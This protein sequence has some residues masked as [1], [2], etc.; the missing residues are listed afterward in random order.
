[1]RI[2]LYHNAPSGGAKRAIFE[3]SIRLAGRY[4][5]DVY[6]LSTG[7]HAYCDIRPIVHSH[8]VY[9]FA[10]RRQFQ[11]PL[12]RLN[13]LQRWRDLVDLD[14]L[15]RLIAADINSRQYDV[16]F[17]HTCLLAMI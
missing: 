10:V 13:Q 6:T 17:A 5:L 2:A 8:R 14:R 7:N 11:S 12:G 16:L 4:T 15:S 9:P 1:M 3:W